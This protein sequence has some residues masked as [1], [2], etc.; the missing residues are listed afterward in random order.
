MVCISERKNLKSRKRQSLA[1]G[2]MATVPH[3]RD[4]GGW[5]VVLSPCFPRP[6]VGCLVLKAVVCHLQHPCEDQEA[7][8]CPAC[9]VM[10]FC[11]PG[12]CLLSPAPSILDDWVTATLESAIGVSVS[13]SSSLH[14]S[15]ILTGPGP[16]FPYKPQTPPSMNHHR[17]SGQH[18]IILS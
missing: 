18:V 11:F 8:L 5:G 14:T 3:S 1:Q 6:H 9:L 15:S 2:L 10:A 7:C 17:P 13:P 12:R 16:L 4:L